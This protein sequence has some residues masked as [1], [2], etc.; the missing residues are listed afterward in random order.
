MEEK[1]KVL[2]VEDDKIDQIAFE[3]FVEREGLRYDYV[4][5]GSVA[6]T[7]DV[8]VTG[9]FDIALVDYL[10]GDGTAFDLID[11]I[12]ETPIIIITGSG[13]EE[14]AVRAMKAGAVDYLIKDPQGNYLTTLPVTVEHT[15]RRQRAEEELQ[16][17][18]ERLEELVEERT[19]ELIVANQQLQQEI[20]ERAQAEIALKESEQQ[21]LTLIDAMPDFVCFKDGDGRWL[22]VN[23]ASISIFQL[24]NIDYR[25]KKDSELAELD[26]RLRD[27]FLTCTETDAMAWKEGRLFHR[28]EMVPHPD[29]T[30]RVYDVTKV[31]VFHP[32]GERKGLVVLGHDI[33]KRVQAEEILQK[34]A[35]QLEVLRQASLSLTSSL[36]MQSV[37]DAILEQ[38]LK[39][40]NAD[41]AHVFLYDGEQLSFGSVLWKDGRTQEPFAEPRQNGLTYNVARIGKSVV[42]PDL[43]DHPLYSDWPLEGAIVGLPL[44]YSDKVIGVMNIALDQPHEFTE[45]ELYILELLADQ[46]AVAIDNARLHEQIQRHAEE[47]EQRVRER[48]QELRDAQVKMIRQEKLAVLGQLAGGVSH[49]LRNPL[50]VISNAVYYLKMVQPDAD[51]KVKEYLEMIESE[52]RG[53][54]KIISDLLDFTRIKSAERESVA[55]S[56]LVATVLAKHP[57]PENVELDTKTPT[58]HLPPVFVDPAQI[59]QVLTNLVTNAYQAMPEGGWLT[60]TIPPRECSA[61]LRDERSP[62][63]ISIT[64]TGEGIPTENMENIFEPLFTTKARGIGMGLVISK[65]LMEANGG[66]IEVESVEDEGTRF[67]LLLPT[68]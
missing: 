51:E 47:L 58:D 67:T 39:L 36:T 65:T 22:K 63:F 60:I 6:E 8:L 23:D 31:P 41:D 37:L 66:S 2:Y 28:E 5:T 57:P 17:H 45:S 33:T 54:A 34:H 4:I 3:R 52:T 18:R 61:A 29:G 55:I 15:L 48:T 59:E 26:S 21:L 38:S 10:L 25:G 13:D 19:A 56:E 53:A 24:E 20:T 68:E 44:R 30:I 32:G 1:I 11:A 50:G 64:D 35:E 9:R 42:V 62:V 14:I 49:E 7:R 40:V 27:T 46:A 16:Q 43:S 12:G